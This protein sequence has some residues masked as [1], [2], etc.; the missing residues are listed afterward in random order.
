MKEM[1]RLLIAALRKEKTD[2]ASGFA[3][4]KASA[5]AISKDLNKLVYIIIFI[6]IVAFFV[7]AQICLRNFRWLISEVIYPKRNQL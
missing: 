7:L 2:E 4:G 5:L 1:I 3:N 6:D